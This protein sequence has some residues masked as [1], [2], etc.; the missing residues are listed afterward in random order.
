MTIDQ[1]IEVFVQ[2]FAFGRSFTHPFVPERIEHGIWVMRD[3]PR[4]SGDYRNEE[5]VA[6]GVSPADMLET[7]RANTRGRFKICAI[8]ASDEPDAELR[9]GYK[10]LGCR[11]M[12]TEAFM[13]HDLTVI[14]AVPEPVEIGRLATVEQANQLA[15]AA[16]RK[17]IL[18]EHLTADPPPMRQYMA[19]DGDKPVGWVGSVAVC[20]AAWCTN[21]FVRPE[22]RRRGIATALMTQMLL[23]DREAGA[24]A[25]VLLASH[26]GAK[27]YPSVGYVQIG[28]LLL[29]SAPAL[30]SLLG[31]PTLR[32]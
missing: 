7:A 31:V 24:T 3:G 8:R 16:R 28:E 10:A 9:S 30:K 15:K 23:D 12:G 14:D 25:N 13:V 6:R 21:M 32:R 19:V 2:G 22:Y 26:A 20:G 18:P 29:Y 4:K 11:L 1:A 5:Y 17:Q 27:L